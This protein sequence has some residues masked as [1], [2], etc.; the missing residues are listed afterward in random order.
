MKDIPIL[1]M[2]PKDKFFGFVTGHILQLRRS[3]IGLMESSVKEYG[4]FI[5][6]KYLHHNVFLIAHPDGAKHVLQKNSRNY[7]KKT[8][9]FKKVMKIG[10]KGI[11]VNEGGHW[12]KMRGII[13][14]YFNKNSIENY[15]P[16]MNLTIDRVIENYKQDLL[17]VNDEMAKLTIQVLGETL[18]DKRFND[19]SEFLYKYVSSLFDITSERMTR[20]LPFPS[21]RRINNDIKFNLFKRKLDQY[22]LNL[23][24]EARSSDEKN[25]LIHK[26]LSSKHS[27]A[28]K[29]I[30]DEVLTLIVAGFET[31]ANALTWAI[32]KIAQDEDFQTIIKNEYNSLNL[33]NLGFEELSKMI[34]TKNVLKESLRRYPGFWVLA[35]L[36]INE[37]QIFNEKIPPKS[38]VLISPYLIQN[39]SKWWDNP[40]QFIPSRFEGNY[41]DNSYLPFGLGPR[42]CIA[43]DFSLAEMSL[44]LGKLCSKFKFNLNNNKEVQVRAGLSLR[45]SEDILIRLK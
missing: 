37:D 25:N 13:Q 18:L 38:I 44:I 2:P 23:I 36:A 12:R 15:L 35:R 34:F 21:F 26:F 29:D 39:N 10:G 40:E 6:F 4:E 3:R 33:N 16:K 42:S 27:V 22:V 7:S 31:S 45:T 24:E 28:L 11:L 8:A 32:Y 41:Y 1:K 17:N 43:E 19:D 14:P 30:L 5:H 9:G 20:F